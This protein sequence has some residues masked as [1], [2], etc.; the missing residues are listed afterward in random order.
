MVLGA[1]LV[2]SK[3]WYDQAAWNA[4]YCEILEN[5]KIQDMYEIFHYHFSQ[6]K[7]TMKNVYV[8]EVFQIMWELD[9]ILNRGTSQC[10]LLKEWQVDFSQKKNLLKWKNPTL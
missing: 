5:L 1:V 9:E 8:S 7:R 4:D 6:S 10:F 2:V 3:V